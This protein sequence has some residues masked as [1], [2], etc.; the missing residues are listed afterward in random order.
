MNCPTRKTFRAENLGRWLLG[1]WGDLKGGKMLTCEDGNLMFFFGDFHLTTT[2]T[3]NEY[4]TI[5]MDG[6]IL[7]S[8]ESRV[9]G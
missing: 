4:I 5:F 9:D 2:Q 7:K 1:Q 3:H 6:S 8:D